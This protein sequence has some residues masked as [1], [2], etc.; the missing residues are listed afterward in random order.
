MRPLCCPGLAASIG[1]RT[2]K[3]LARATLIHSANALTWVEYLRRVDSNDIRPHHE[4]WFDR[5][6]MAI[7]AAISGLGV[8]LESEILAAQ[9]LSDGKLVAPFT[10]PRFEVETTSY[11]LVRSAASRNRGQIAA[12]ENWLRAAIAPANLA[13]KTRS[14]QAPA[15]GTGDAGR[16]V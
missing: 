6:T 15:E 16:S 13:M 10:D 4:L 8:I 5:S 7:E 2:P 11:F 9:E 14:L 12:F 3:D 1:L